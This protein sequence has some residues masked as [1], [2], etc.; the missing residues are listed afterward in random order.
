MQRGC[1][2]TSSPLFVCGGCERYTYCGSQCADN[3]W[4]QGKHAF[5]CVGVRTD[6]D[7]WNFPYRQ[8]SSPDVS[9]APSPRRSPSYNDGYDEHEFSFNPNNEDEREDVVLNSQKRPSDDDDYD[10]PYAQ[11]SP[12]TP[13][14]QTESDSDSD[15]VPPT[16]TVVTPP[17][18]LRSKKE[19]YTQN[20]PP[21]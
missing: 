20:S 16:V 12:K 5:N 11:S 19:F 13:K 10:G 3:H 9:P 6:D 21:V 4:K 17:H 8:P 18:R 1:P 2:H 7:E 14:R 15:S